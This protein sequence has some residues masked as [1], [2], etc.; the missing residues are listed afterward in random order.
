MAQACPDSDA[1]PLRSPEAGVCGADLEGAACSPRSPS[2]SR[3]TPMSSAWPVHPGPAPAA[4]A[5]SDFSQ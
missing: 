5:R 2:S 1:L 4:P 3:S